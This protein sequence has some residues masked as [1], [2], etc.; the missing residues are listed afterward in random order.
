MMASSE[1]ERE[2]MY[3]H[4]TLLQP[5]LG[6][7]ASCICVYVLAS[8]WTADV[9]KTERERDVLR[10]TG[11]A[12]AGESAGRKGGSLPSD[13]V[14]EKSTAAA[15]DWQGEVTAAWCLLLCGRESK[16]AFTGGEL[17]AGGRSKK[18]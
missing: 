18:K 14:D 4:E 10:R 7:K 12:V 5:M 6:N 17:G 8:T 16:A 1:K 13:R 3:S 15:A 2:W 11:V 9:G